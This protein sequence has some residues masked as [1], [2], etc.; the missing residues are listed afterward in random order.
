[1]TL[2]WALLAG[3]L[4]LINPCVLPLL[5]IIIASS[6]QQGRSGPLALAAGLVVSFV[7]IGTGV[8]AFGHLVGLDIDTVN[9]V[10]AGVMIVFGAVLLLPP[11]QAAFASASAPLAGVAD[12]QLDRQGRDGVAGQFS[13]GLLLGAVWSPCVGPTL[14]GAIGLAASGEHLGQAAATMFAFGIG[15]AVVLLALSYGSRELIMARRARLQRL[16]PY[17]KPVMGGVLLFVGVALWF[18][19]QRVAEDWLLDRMPIWLQ[20]ASVLI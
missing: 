15:V 5:P 9:R 4:T 16:M 1:M 13:I 11:L 12:R 7:V 19:W 10:A 6:L 18:H 2:F 20:D 3:M 17:A 8:T 14:G